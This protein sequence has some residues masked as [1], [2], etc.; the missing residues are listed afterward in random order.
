MTEEITLDGR[1]L[2]GVANTE[3]GEVSCDTPFKFEQEGKRIYAHYSGGD[4]IDGHLVGTFDGR[5]WEIKYS[6]INSEYETAIGISIHLQSA[7]LRNRERRNRLME[8]DYGFDPNPHS[9][10][11]V[12]TVTLL[13]DGRVRVEDE[14][15]WDSHDGSGE[16][17][18]EE[19]A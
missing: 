9:G 3:G 13:D 1:T 14:W 17:V 7:L 15:E 19:V 16:S 8:A 5:E 10:H 4:I 18:L 12:G 6:Q 11:S 2:V